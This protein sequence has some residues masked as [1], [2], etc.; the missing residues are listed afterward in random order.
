MMNG[1]ANR[2]YVSGAFVTKNP[3][4]VQKLVS[5][6][7]KAADVLIKTPAKAAPHVGAALGK[8]IVDPA[9]IEKALTSPATR[10]EIER[11]SWVV[12]NLPPARVWVYR[13]FD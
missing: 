10:F 13:R 4:A 11:S 9:L 2:S 6:L 8:G 3:N 5:S 1:I 7:V 12:R